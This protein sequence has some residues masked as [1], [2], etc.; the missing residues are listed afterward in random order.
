MNAMCLPPVAV[1]LSLQSAN[2][3]GELVRRVLVVAR[4]VSFG[5][6]SFQTGPP[7]APRCLAGYR[8][9]SPRCLRARCAVPP[10]GPPRDRTT[11]PLATPRWPEGS[12][13]FSR[14][15]SRLRPASS[16]RVASR[17]LPVFSRWALRRCTAGSRS[18]LAPSLSSLH[19]VAHAEV[20][21]EAAV[22]FRSSLAFFGQVK[23]GRSGGVDR[24]YH[25][26][27]TDMVVT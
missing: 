8:S 5:S 18:V 14:T 26:G 23:F 21:S 6:V 15:R 20:C 7:N 22:T 9:R 17:A 16:T 12:V 19:R 25:G 10:N 1:L 27:R 11:A 24:P 4:A 13:G 3:H 2:C